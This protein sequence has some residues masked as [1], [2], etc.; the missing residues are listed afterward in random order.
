MPDADPPPPDTEGLR[1]LTTYVQDGVVSRAQLRALGFRPHDVRRML[2]RRDLGVVHPGVYVQHTG[3]PTSP[4]RAWAAVLATGGVLT[5]ESALPRP[6]EGAPVQVAIDVRRTVARL[7]GVTVHRTAHLADRVAAGS[8]PPRVVPAHAALDLAD[9]AADDHAA[10]RVLADVLHTRVVTVADLSSALAARSRLRRR[11]LLVELVAD[12]AAGAA[13][14]LERAYLRDV[15]RAHGLPV[16]RRQARGSVDGRTVLRDVAYDGFGTF[17]ELDGRAF[18]DTPAARD[19]DL[20]RDLAAAVADQRTTVRLGYR[21][22][23][24]DACGTADAVA[25]LLQRRGWRG[26]PVACPRCAGRRS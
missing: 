11:G 13:S 17:V 20:A 18:H 22:V 1:H 12:L 7:D 21:Q 16:G 5:R 19:R 15:E 6:P 3:P 2:R 4:Q 10:Y 8:S 25:L 26:V 23:L 9:S 24:G 14:V